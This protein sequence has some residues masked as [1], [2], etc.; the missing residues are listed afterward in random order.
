MDSGI[1]FSDQ[2]SIPKDDN[3][4]RDK[5][6]IPIISAKDPNINKGIQINRY[7]MLPSGPN[8]EAT[9]LTTLP[10]VARQKKKII[11]PA[12]MRSTLPSEEGLEGWAVGAYLLV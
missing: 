10:T 3:T 11:T 6:I 9:G 8:K 12:N 4:R 5:Y 7:P 1:P 2:P